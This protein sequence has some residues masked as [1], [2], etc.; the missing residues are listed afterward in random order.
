MKEEKDFLFSVESNP[1]D[2]TFLINECVRL[3]RNCVDNMELFDTLS[4][5]D[6]L[7]IL[8]QL[9]KLSKG[10][11]IE[12]TYRCVNPECSTFVKNDK[13]TE[14]KTGIP[15]AGNIPYEA[16]L[17]LEEDFVVT[18][19]NSEPFKIGKY[20]LY[21]KEMSFTEQMELEKEY[22]GDEKKISIRKFQHYFMLHSIA[23]IEVEGDE[24]VY[25]N[26]TI[27]ELD[28]LVDTFSPKESAEMDEKIVERKTSFGIEKKVTCPACQ[29]QSDVVY[30]ELFSI[31]VF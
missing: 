21:V 26:P 4:R 12:F 5:N 10:G 30:E 6:L 7:Y 9:R 16:R 11:T 1:D 3:G 24:E 15:G 8:T 14:E 27:E 29:H 23:K 22:L 13:E 31:M 25:E 28:A 2:R 17:D 19:F 20:T 18:F